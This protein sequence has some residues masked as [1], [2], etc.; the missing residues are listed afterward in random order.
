MRLFLALELP[1]AVKQHL[2][3]LPRT[4]NAAVKHTPAENLHVTLKFLGEVEPAAAEMLAA[5]LRQVD[6]QPPAEV[7]AGHPEILPP[8]GSVRVIS[9]GLDGDVARVVELQSAVEAACA[10]HGFLREGRRYLPHI[11]LARARQPL[12]GSNRQ[13]LAEVLRSHLPSPAFRPGGFTLMQS[14]L[15]GPAPKYVALER[16]DG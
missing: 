5:R 2:A 3:G 13:R 6:V 4:D 12:P 7:W 11:T 8:R 14:Q 10:E 9:A 15:G 16:F 1:D